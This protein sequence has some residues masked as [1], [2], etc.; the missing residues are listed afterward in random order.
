MAENQTLTAILDFVEPLVAVVRLTPEAVQSKAGLPLTLE[1]PAAPSAFAIW[2]AQS[3]SHHFIDELELRLSLADPL[4]S[5][6]LI[7][8]TRHTQQVTEAVVR[9]RLGMPDGFF[10]PPPTQK[11]GHMLTWTYRRAGSAQLYFWLMGKSSGMQ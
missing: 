6:L 11:S 4:V 8:K 1:K 5:W 10:P 3:T 9:E 2:K 7:I